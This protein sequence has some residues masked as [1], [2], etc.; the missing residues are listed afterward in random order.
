[1]RVSCQEYI[2]DNCDESAIKFSNDP[3]QNIV[4]DS[5]IPRVV[6]SL[7]QNEQ[8][9]FEHQND[10]KIFEHKS[11]DRYAPKD[12]NKIQRTLVHYD[13]IEEIP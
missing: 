2:F 13:K 10:R 3:D 7:N 8:K 12:I 11:P 4:R 5:E 6:Q 1:M 9:I